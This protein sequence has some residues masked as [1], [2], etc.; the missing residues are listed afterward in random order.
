MVVLIFFELFGL[1]Q[2][3]VD[4]PLR[5]VGDDDDAEV[6]A[7]LVGEATRPS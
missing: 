7:F 1:G 6:T 5:G 2:S 3:Y 4:K